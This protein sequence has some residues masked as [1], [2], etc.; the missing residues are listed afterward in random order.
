MPEEWYRAWRH[1]ERDREE[2]EARDV[3]FRRREAAK[4]II[5]DLLIVGAIVAFA[6]ASLPV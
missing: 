6:W 3:R 1:E 5:G 4:R 2:R